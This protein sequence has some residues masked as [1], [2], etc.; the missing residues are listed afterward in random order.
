M[1]TAR[2][3][4]AQSRHD[5]FSEKLESLRKRFEEKKLEDAQL[6]ASHSTGGKDGEIE[7]PRNTD[8]IVHSLP[9]PSNP[10]PSIDVSD[11]DGDDIDALCLDF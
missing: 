9:S 4:V 3:K 1:L 6:I 8:E 7:P 5:P 11:D 2:T 10:Q